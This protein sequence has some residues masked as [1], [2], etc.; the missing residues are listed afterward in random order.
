MYET[1]VLTSS[2]VYGVLE[3]GTK[4]GDSTQYFYTEVISDTRRKISQ[5]LVAFDEKSVNILLQLRQTGEAKLGSVHGILSL[6]VR[7]LNET[8]EQLT[9]VGNKTRDSETVAVVNFIPG[10]SGFEELGG[11]AQR[12]G[13]CDITRPFVG[14]NSIHVAKDEG[15]SLRPA[16][17]SDD[18]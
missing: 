16:S 15:D 14:H 4:S 10:C 11:K 3:S 9:D 6:V 1:F 17:I 2:V 8:N 5:L 7:E 18:H 13:P 12:S